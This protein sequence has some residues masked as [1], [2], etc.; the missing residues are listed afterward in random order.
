MN[1]DAQSSLLYDTVAVYLAFSESLLEMEQLP[2]IVTD[3]GRTLVDDGGQ[4]VN[5]AMQWKDQTAFESL[6]TERLLNE[7]QR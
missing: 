2:I 6:L 1:P 4:L 3:D 7:E 5:C